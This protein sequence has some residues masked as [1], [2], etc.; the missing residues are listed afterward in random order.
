MYEGRPNIR[1]RGGQGG[2]ESEMPLIPP[3]TAPIQAHAQ[4]TPD[5]S[6]PLPAGR[7]SPAGGCPGV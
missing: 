6:R 5:P 4:P 3:Y 2:Q 7:P 1:R